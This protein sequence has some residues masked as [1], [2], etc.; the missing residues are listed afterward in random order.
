[1]SVIYLDLMSPLSSS[2]LPS[3]M[4]RAALH[5]VGLHDLTTPKTYGSRV[6]TRPVGSY[7]TFSP[8]PLRREAVIFFYVTL[9]SRIAFC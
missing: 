7:P 2:G 1:V 5:S 9:P 6:A 4:G 8:L 3:D